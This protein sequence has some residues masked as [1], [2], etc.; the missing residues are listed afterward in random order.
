AK[1]II[2]SLSA[3]PKHAESK[4][5]VADKP[6]IK[7]LNVIEDK[8]VRGLAKKI[9]MA[10]TRAGNSANQVVD[11]ILSGLK[12]AGKHSD[13]VES[14]V[15][16]LAQ[17][18]QVKTESAV[19][20]TAVELDVKQLNGIEDRITRSIAKKAFMAAKREGKST[21]EIIQAIR[22]ALEAESKLTDEV[23]SQLETLGGTK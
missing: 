10:E 6:H 5:P 7:I 23:K 21:P 4:A 2:E 9:F 14:V 22:T 17:S 18:G 15:R 19:S 12:E 11:A 8:M 3:S 16:Q 20:D 13:D 1:T